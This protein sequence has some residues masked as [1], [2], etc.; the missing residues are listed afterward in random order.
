MA[1]DHGMPPLTVFVCFFTCLFVVVFSD[2][3]VSRGNIMHVVNVDC[4]HT[5]NETFGYLV[6]ISISL[7]L[8]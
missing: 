4:V 1:M 3:Q 7:A 6:Q 5:E 2:Y 8:W